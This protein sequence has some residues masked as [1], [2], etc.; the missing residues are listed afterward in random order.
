MGQRLFNIDHSL[1]AEFF[2]NDPQ[3]QTGHDQRWFRVQ[4]IEWPET[5]MCGFVMGLWRKIG[6]PL[7]QAASTDLAAR[8]SFS[9]I[10]RRVTGMGRRF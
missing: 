8:V 3:P 7:A 6:H 4:D 10:G 2:V 1:S 9:T 5:R